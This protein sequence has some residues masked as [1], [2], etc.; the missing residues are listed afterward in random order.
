MSLPSLMKNC[1]WTE[2]RLPANHF[3]LFSKHLPFLIALGYM[4]TTVTLYYDKQSNLLTE[5]MA[6]G[7]ARERVLRLSPKPSFPQF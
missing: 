5:T 3:L 4:L 1:Q 2:R 6:P 7:T